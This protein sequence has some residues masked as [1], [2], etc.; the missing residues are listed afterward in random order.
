MALPCLHAPA[1]PAKCI[2]DDL[3]RPATTGGSRALDFVLPL[4]EWGPMSIGKRFKAWRVRR[5]WRTDVDESGLLDLPV[6]IVIL[7]YNRR[8]FITWN[9][10]SLLATTVQHRNLEIIVWDNASQDGT[11][12]A[13]LPYANSGRIRVIT[14]PKN[15]GTNAYHHAF[16]EARGKYL[17]DMDDDVIWFP[18]GWLGALLR[19]FLH[20]PRLGFLSA[21][22]I[23]DKYTAELHPL[24]RKPYYP[25]TFPDGTTIAMGA[26]SGHCAVTTAE[27]YEEVG[28]F[29]L[30]EAHF[31]VSEDG[32]YNRVLR[33]A[34]YV[35]G[36]LPAV[37]VYHA[38]G[39][40]CN[41]DYWDVF[42]N[43]CTDGAATMWV[44]KID[45]AAAIPGFIEYFRQKNRAR[46]DAA[47]AG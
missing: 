1:T 45:R 6:T 8:Q 34:G 43:K 12:E 2:T 26:A 5:P 47:P 35:R 41:Y 4:L 7:T 29:P 3:G 21:S 33:K 15:I 18:P 27:I 40:H 39:P 37:E 20:L 9:L 10:D 16:K 14:S 11:R 23:T 13:L 46:R 32:H 31:F 25:V 24:K 38:L 30:D 19:C 42:V 28:G 44:P 36:I 22:Q 17:I